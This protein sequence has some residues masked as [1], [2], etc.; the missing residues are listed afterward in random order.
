MK[1]GTKLNHE[2]KATYMVTVTA[3]DPGGLSDSVDVTIKVTD[4]DEAP[5][6]TAGGLVISGM[7]RVDYAEDRRDA[8]ATYRASGPD[9]D[10]ATWTLS[11]GRR[12]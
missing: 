3:T 6:I 1:T 8:V 11:G 5:E 9:A 2:A 4:E 7:A 12:R 10:M